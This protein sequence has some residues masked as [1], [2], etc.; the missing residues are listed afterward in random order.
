MATFNQW[1]L[2]ADSGEVR[3]LTWVCGD[4]AVLVEEVIDTIRGLLKPS[5]LDYVSLHAGAVPDRDIWAAGAQY[6]LT[7]GANRLILIRDAQAMK[8]FD[9]LEGWL[10]NTRRLPG[11]HLLFVADEP[12]LPYERDERGKKTQLKPHALLMQQRKRSCQLVR[13]ALPNPT[14]AVAWVRRRAPLDADT[15]G[16]LLT[17]VGGNLLHA[18]AVCGKLAVFTAAAGPPVIDALAEEVPA[19]CF[20]ENLLFGRKRDALAAIAGLAPAQYPRLISTLDARLDTLSALWR[21]L[22]SGYGAREVAGLPY[23]L[24]RH[25]TP[26]ANHYDPARCAYCRRLLAVVDDAYATGARDA[27]L[28]ALVALW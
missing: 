27:L 26:I 14:D 20:T 4:Q 9:P 7:P 24:V 3:R 19:D 11:V 8:R 22:R 28:E 10:D 18:A 6:P 13:C 25:Y 15:A 21:H 5:E 12:D 2:A 23:F 17:R 1:R 16:Y